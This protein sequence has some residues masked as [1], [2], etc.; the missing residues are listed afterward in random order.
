M[1]SLLGE[2]KSIQR[3]FLFCFLKGGGALEYKMM[4]VHVFSYLGDILQLGYRILC[5]WK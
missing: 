2:K 1:F 4:E 3:F 5:I